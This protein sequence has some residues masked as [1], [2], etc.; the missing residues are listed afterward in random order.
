MGREAENE[1]LPQVVRLLA[2]VPLSLGGGI[3]QFIMVDFFG[4]NM[5]FWCLQSVNII[6]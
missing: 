4:I 3:R 2:L 5:G 6:D 1:R